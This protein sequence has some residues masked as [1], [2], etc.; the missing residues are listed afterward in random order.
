MDYEPK[1]EKFLQTYVFSEHGNYYV[2][3]ARFSSSALAASDM[4]YY[5][6]MAW[7]QVENGSGK[8]FAQI[9][10]SSTKKARQN[11]MDVVTQ[12]QE[13]GDYKEPEEI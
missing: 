1:N 13:T 7:E 2:S 8:C 11:H 12:L 10:T 6:T 3:T 9:Q 5:E 4:M